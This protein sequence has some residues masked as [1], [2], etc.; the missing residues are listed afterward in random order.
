MQ[1]SGYHLVRNDRGLKPRVP[2]T[3]PDRNPSSTTRSLP[4]SKKRRSVTLPKART[5]LAKLKNSRLNAAI[6]HGVN[7]KRPRAFVQGGGVAL[8]VRYGLRFKVLANS[9]ISSINESEYLIIEIKTEKDECYLV[10]ALYR[11]PKGNVLSEFFKT[12]SQYSHR[13]YNTIILGDLNSDLMQNDYYSVHLQLLIRE[14]SLFLVPSGTSHHTDAAHTWLDVVLI[15]NHEKLVDFIKSSAPFICGHD[16]L[17]I[18]YISKEE[19]PACKV[20][21]SRDFRRFNAENFRNSLQHM[22][23]PLLGPADRMRNVNDMLQKFQETLLKLLDL[24]APFTERSLRKN[25]APWFNKSLRDRCRRRDRLYNRA[26][27]QRSRALLRQYRH[28]RNTLQRDLRLAKEKFFMTKLNDSPSPSTIWS[29]LTNLGVVGTRKNSPLAVFSAIELNTHFAS[30]ASVHPVCTDNELNNILSKPSNTSFPAFKLQ[31]LDHVHVLQTLMASLPNAKGRSSDG[32]SLCYFKNLLSPIA[33]YLTVIYNMSIETGVYPDLWKKALVIPL[34]KVTTPSSPSETRPIANLPHFAKIFDKLV[35][36]QLIDHLEKY[37][38]LTPFQSGFR[39]SYSTQAALLKISEDFRKGIDNGLLTIL[40][41]FD[42]KKAFDSLKHSTLLQKMQ[43]LNFS[44]QSILWFRSYLTGRSQAIIDLKGTCSEFLGV[45]SGIPQGSNPG[46]VVFLILINSIVSCLRH[47]K[48]TCMLFADDFQIYIQCKRS[49]LPVFIE[50]LNEDIESVANWAEVNNLQLN[51]DKTTAIIIGSNQ[52]V[53]RINT[54]E[55]PPLKLA[56]SCIP[57]RNSVKNL[58][59]IFS[60][61]LTWNLQISSI[62]SRVHGVLKRLRFRSR[63]LTP[64]MKKLL[65]NALVIPLF[66]YACVV[67]CDLSGYLETKLQRL[68]NFAVKFIFRLKRDTALAPYYK[69]LNW[70]TIASRRKYF[71]ALVTRQVLTQA[72]PSYLLPLFPRVGDEVRRSTRNK[73][74]TSTSSFD[75]PTPSTVTLEKSFSQQSMKLWDILPC[76]IKLKATIGTFKDAL[77]SYL[78]LN[79]V[80]PT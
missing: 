14:Y 1:I 43:E 58:G 76:D 80:G 67:F 5:H 79:D 55:L 20:I 19:K 47:C 3:G 48:E 72:K 52:N 25:P 9:K 7:A 61:D 75:I 22:L 17:I 28:I 49:E 37:N 71:M 36:N 11:R 10:A 51:L 42:F 53:T 68:Q 78:L 66:D 77:Y 59:L 33:K 27:R 16:S 21:R 38:L 65:V 30:V 73:S 35:A 31:K 64:T 40:V 60:H 44:D 29:L 34:N 23:A 54:T 4:T 50:K 45:T 8:Y 2:A 46:P 57:L 69:R 12:F 56:G 62:C 13:Y 6:K 32:L 24:H 41:L 70:L 26:V 18:D 15:D 39:K 74:D 63:Y